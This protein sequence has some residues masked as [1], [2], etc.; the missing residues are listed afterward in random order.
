M[1]EKR[2]VLTYLAGKEWVILILW[3]GLSFISAILEVTRNSYNN[4]VIFRNVFYHVCDQLPLYIPYPNEYNDVNLYGPVFSLV[5]APFALLPIG[6]GALLWS[7]GGTAALYFA[8][9]KLPITRIQQGVVL[10]LC[11][12][13]MMGASTWFQLNQY[14]GAFIILTFVYTIKGKEMWA[15]FFI[16]LGTLTKFYGIVGLAFFFFSPNPWRFIYSLILWSVV[17]FVLPMAISSPT[18]IVHSYVEWIEALV[19]KNAINVDGFVTFQDLSAGGFIKRVFHIPWLSNMAVLI[20]AT[21]IFMLQY[22]R[23]QY[24]FNSRY[25]LYILC[26]ALLFPVLFSTSAESPTYIIA[27]P[28]LCIW[29]AIQPAT[30]ANNIYIFFSILLVSFSHS[31]L[32][33]PWFRTNIAI[34]YAIKA[35]PCLVMYLR[36][37]YEI[38]TKQFLSKPTDTIL[39]SNKLK[40]VAG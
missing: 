40:T 21:L 4:Y 18:Y 35:L 24:R 26:S 11:S 39:T 3:F 25:R 34:P 7:M 37:A 10:I 30:R 5:I 15:A 2:N 38:Y 19:H 1:R 8:I 17:L 31:D 28:A 32:L 23:L 9:R 12:Q 6:I 33:T 27:V 13:E 22:T 36:L 20:P 16:V 14:I 29:Y